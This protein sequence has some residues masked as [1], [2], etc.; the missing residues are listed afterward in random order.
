M[1]AIGIDLAAAFTLVLITNSQARTK[2]LTTNAHDELSF[3][4]LP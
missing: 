4:Y 1:S 3:S 2:V